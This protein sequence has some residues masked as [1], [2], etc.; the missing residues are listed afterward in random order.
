MSMPPQRVIERDGERIAI[1]LSGN[2]WPDGLN[3]LSN[4][5]DFIQA[6]TWLYGKGRRLGPHIHNQVP[7]EATRTQEIIFVRSGRLR[8]HLFDSKGDPIESL[9]LG[10][11]DLLIALS[12]GHGYEVL[13]EGTTVLEVKNGPYIGP[14]ADRRKIPWQE[15]TKTDG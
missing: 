15:A 5:G 14:E 9:E 10:P 4:D 12:G 6:G 8:A 3:F 7:R 2:A 13:E 11:G 1:F